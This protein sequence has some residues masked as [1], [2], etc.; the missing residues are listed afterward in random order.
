[1]ELNRDQMI[2]MAGARAGAFYPRAIDLET[3]AFWPLI[4]NDYNRMTAQMVG[5]FDNVPDP[6]HTAKRGRPRKA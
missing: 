4:A 1:M 2:F 5:A 6:V 3:A